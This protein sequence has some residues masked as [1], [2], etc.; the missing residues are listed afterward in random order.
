M[1]LTVEYT[2]ESLALIAF[3]GRESITT[4]HHIFLG[5]VTEVDVGTQ[6]GIHILVTLVYKS[7]KPVQINSFH[8]GI[9]AIS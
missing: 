9:E 4:N 6:T 1:T 5:I 3:V 2:L 7:G 8:K